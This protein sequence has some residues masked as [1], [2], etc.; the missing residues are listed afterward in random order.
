MHCTNTGCVAKINDSALLYSGGASTELVS[1]MYDVE[2]DT[3]T[4]KSDM[5]EYRNYHGCGSID[6]QVGLK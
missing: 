5:S 3:W 4:R 1:Y 6:T 2:R